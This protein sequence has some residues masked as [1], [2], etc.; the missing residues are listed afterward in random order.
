MANLG[1]GLE[2]LDERTQEGCGVLEHP[3][4]IAYDEVIEN[5]KTRRRHTTVGGCG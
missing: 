4:L 2:K 3:F 1:E 5:T